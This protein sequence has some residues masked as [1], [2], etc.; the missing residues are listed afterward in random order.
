[1]D[2]EPSLRTNTTIFYGGVVFFILQT[3]TLFCI[4][5]IAIFGLY[6]AWLANFSFFFSAYFREGCFASERQYSCQSDCACLPQGDEGS[7]SVRAA[8]FCA[9]RIGLQSFLR[10]AAH[11]PQD[12]ACRRG[13]AAGSI[14]A[15][16]RS[17]FRLRAGS[18]LCSIYNACKA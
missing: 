3:T 13:H 5:S 4:P 15:C 2:P 7:I 9:G 12:T 17:R 16:A 18:V 6:A 1:M 11:R 14:W 10:P 8:C